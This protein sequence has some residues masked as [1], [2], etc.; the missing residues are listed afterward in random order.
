VYDKYL[1]AKDVSTDKYSVETAYNDQITSQ[2]ISSK[3]MSDD[4]SLPS[5]TNSGT[6][7]DHHLT[8]QDYINV[9]EGR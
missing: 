9:L 3:L 1:G 6:G 4:T 8:L 2:Y 5:Y 7:T